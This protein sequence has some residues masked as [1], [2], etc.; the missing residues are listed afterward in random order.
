[1]VVVL[2]VDAVVVVAEDEEES[3]FVERLEDAADALE[4]VIG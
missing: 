4:F 3:V 1:V 2:V